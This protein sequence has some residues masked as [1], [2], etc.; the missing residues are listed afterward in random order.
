METLVR[1]RLWLDSEQEGQN[2]FC[3]KYPAAVVTETL[4]RKV[5]FLGLEDGLWRQQQ[6]RSEVTA[7]FQNQQTDQ[8]R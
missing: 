7:L 6:V 1:Q 8:Q 2:V 5:P 3:C 4:R